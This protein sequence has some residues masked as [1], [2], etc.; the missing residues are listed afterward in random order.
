MDNKKL[1]DEEKEH[2]RLF[3]EIGERV[4]DRLNLDIL[5]AKSRLVSIVTMDVVAIS[6][7]ASVRLYLLTLE[8]IDLV[9]HENIICGVPLGI[10]VLSW[11]VAVTGIY[12]KIHTIEILPAKKESIEDYFSENLDGFYLRLKENLI[13]SLNDDNK[14]YKEFT[15]YF[16]VSLLFMIMGVLIF[17]SLIVIEIIW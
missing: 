10:L 9:I 7:I 11:V 2:I 5:N 17:C 8:N 16:D 3:L 12:K 14:T 1:S 13:T 6:I 4:Y 15:K